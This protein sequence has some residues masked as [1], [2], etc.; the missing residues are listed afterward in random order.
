MPFFFFTLGYVHEEVK[1]QQNRCGA[2]TSPP[3]IA[4]PTRPSRTTERLGKPLEALLVLLAVRFDSLNR[5]INITS[6]NLHV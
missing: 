5:Q 4:P 3:P 6:K 1:G 2:T